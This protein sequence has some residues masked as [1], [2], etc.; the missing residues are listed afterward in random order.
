MLACICIYV[1]VCMYVHCMYVFLSKRYLLSTNHQ[2]EQVLFKYRNT[3]QYLK[4]LP[5]TTPTWWT[6][7]DLKQNHSKLW[8]AFPCKNP[9]SLACYCSQL[10]CSAMYLV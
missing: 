3:R 6:I 5:Y 1:F 9:L 7:Q 4:H 8:N 10:T 2:D